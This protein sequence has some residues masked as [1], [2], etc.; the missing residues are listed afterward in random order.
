MPICHS[1]D[2]EQR[3]ESEVKE[4]R[5]IAAPAF[6]LLERMPYPMMNT[7]LDGAFPRG[8]LSYWKST[9]LVG[10]PAE[11]IAV[12]VAA[13]E[14]VPSPMSALA[15]EYCHGAMTRVASDATAFPHRGCGFNVLVVGQW[16]D[17]ADTAAN[18]AW[19]RETFDALQP[20][21][22]DACYVNYLSD[23]DVGR[24][25]S[26]YGQNHGRLVELKRRYDPGNLFRLNQN[27]DPR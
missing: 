5:G 21:A 2:D 23:D 16:T 19:T 27:I 18:I 14:R 8:A 24:T 22:A 25:H 10:L 6:D 13:Y 4:L 15:I 20:W 11:A 1:G 3:A 26:A 7:L 9:Y 12:L 17:P